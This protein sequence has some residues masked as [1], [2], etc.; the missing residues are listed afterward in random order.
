VKTARAI[1]NTS[2]YGVLIIITLMTLFPFLWGLASSFRTTDEL[3]KYAI[4]FS[5]KTLIPQ[6]PT[7][8]AYIK[9]FVSYNFLRPILNTLI[10]TA[11]QILLVSLINSA[12][13]FGFAFFNFKLKGLIFAVVLVS[14]MMPGDAILLPLYMLVHSLGWV[15]TFRG[16]II[17]SIADGFVMFLY[18]QF[19]RDIPVSLIEA[20]RVDGAGWVTIF[21]KI[22][23]P[24]SVVVFITA[25]LMTFMNIWNS[26]FWPLLVARNR[27]IQMVQ[28]ALSATR[29]E[30]ST[31]WA[32]LYAGSIIAALIPLLLF[33]P[34]QK[35]FV[36]GYIGTGIKG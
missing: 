20:A 35:Y 13:A 1:R 17:P 25:G 34:F 29:A 16:L 18:V 12:A 30:H 7:F 28:I 15:D 9:L 36:Q 32:V 24:S 4:P 33:L 22:V 21:L 23:I 19:F 14:F 6:E 26:Y 31:D 2:L 11:V 5:S 8:A 3:F 27:N 10:I